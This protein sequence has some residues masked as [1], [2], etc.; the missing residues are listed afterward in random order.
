[1]KKTVSFK[2]VEIAQYAMV[3][4]DH[5]SADGLPLCLAWEADVKSLFKIDE[6]ENAKPVPRSRHQ[7]WMPAQYREDMLL[8]TGVTASEMLRITKE[9]RRIQK[10]RHR[11]IKNQKWDKL[12]LFLEETGKKLKKITSLASL[13][14]V[15]SSA[16]LRS[17]D[18]SSSSNDLEAS[19][20]ALSR[21]MAKSKLSSSSRPSSSSS[22]SGKNKYRS[23]DPLDDSTRSRMAVHLL[24]HPED[25]VV[26]EEELPTEELSDL[27][28][29][30]MNHNDA[31]LM[32][33]ESIVF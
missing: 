25:L 8:R 19:S 31:N 27:H 5:P 2:S 11:S 20:S 26:D 3:L 32:Y 30:N 28:T 10:S 9:T 14:I 18:S 33:D 4:G 13:R 21:I 6:Y 17:L 12:H 24:Q 15:P 22:S 29:E 16:S 7:F 1:M 23:I